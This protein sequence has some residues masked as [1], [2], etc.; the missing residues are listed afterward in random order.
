M[1]C[2]YDCA[3]LSCFFLIVSFYSRRGGVKSVFISLV[4]SYTY[5]VVIVLIGKSELRVWNSFFLQYL[6]EFILGMYFTEQYSKNPENIKI[7]RRGCLLMAIVIGMGLTGY[8]AMNGVWGKMFN[9]I[10]LLVGFMS[11]ALFVYSFKNSAINKCFSYINKFS[12]E[13]YLV[14][15]LVFTIVFHLCG[16]SIAMGCVAFILSYSCGIG[17][18][19]MIS[20]I[21]K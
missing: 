2:E 17:F 6:W 9:D 11:V 20:K 10:P 13:W 15:I 14:H 8:M 19:K 18:Q 21:L 1:V 7:P 5:A 12:Y 4:I 16:N 3:V